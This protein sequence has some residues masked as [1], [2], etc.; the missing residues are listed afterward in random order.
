M[1]NKKEEFN[2]D[3][4]ILEIARE[5]QPISSQEI[6]MEIGENIDLESNP[7][8]EGVSQILDKMEKEKILESTKS[9]N[10]EEKYTVVEK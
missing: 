9:K 2:L 7:S 4:I 8:Q 5:M 6:W 3:E 10:Q 1:N